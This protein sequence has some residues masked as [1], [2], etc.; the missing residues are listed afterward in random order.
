MLDFLVSIR[1]TRDFILKCKLGPRCHDSLRSE[2][3]PGHA[4]EGAL[5]LRLLETAG[6][7]GGTPEPGCREGNKH[8]NAGPSTSKAPFI[9]KPFIRR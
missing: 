7:G 9:T 6:G 3:D 8:R 5:G 2:L 1:F 4:T